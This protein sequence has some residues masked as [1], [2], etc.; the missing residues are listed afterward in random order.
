MVEREAEPD[1]RSRPGQCLGFRAKQVDVANFAS[2]L[3]LGKEIFGLV[4]ADVE[5]DSQKQNNDRKP[6][7]CVG[8][9]F[10][11]WRYFGHCIICEDG[12]MNG[13]SDD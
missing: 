1:G 3:V 2:V 11:R 5:L 9:G 7:Q 10:D 8:L 12:R 6:A 4:Q 13:R